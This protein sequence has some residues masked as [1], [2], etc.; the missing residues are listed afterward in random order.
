MPAA[1][2]GCSCVMVVSCKIVQIVPA[3]SKLVMKLHGPYALFADGY[4]LHR[5]SRAEHVEGG[6]ILL[7]EGVAREHRGIEVA[8]RSEEHTS[9]LQ[10]LMRS[11]YAVFCLKKRNP[12]RATATPV[13]AHPTSAG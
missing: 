7:V 8:A 9:E 12:Q 11:S 10:S 5:Q 4:G 1:V 6:T 13:R 2:R 3:S